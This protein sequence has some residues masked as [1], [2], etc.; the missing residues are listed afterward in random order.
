MMRFRWKKLAAVGLAAVG[1]LAVFCSS[2]AAQNVNLKQ[3]LEELLPGMGAEQG[4][5]KP[6]QRWQELCNQLGAPGQE[7]RRSEVC[8]LMAAKLASPAATPRARIWLLKQ[9]ERIGRG[10]CVDAIAAL[11]A[12]KE[13]LVQSAAI[14]ALANNPAPAAGEKLRDA[15]RMTNDSRLMIELVNAL[16][17]RGD[18]ESTEILSEELA[19]SDGELAGV[20]AR[21]LAKI[22]SPGAVEALKAALLRSSGQVRLE[23]GDALARCGEKLLAEGDVA[24]ARAIARLLYKPKEPARLAGLVGLLRTSGDDAGEA[25]LDVLAHGDAACDNI[26]IGYVANVESKS[27][28]QLADGLPG[29]PPAAQAALLHALGARR[30][31]TALEAVAQAAGSSDPAVKTAA[32]EALGGIGDRSSVPVLVQAITVGGAL[33]SIAQKSLET[34]F[35]EGVDAAIVD[36]MKKTDDPKR[37]CQYIEI[38]EHRRASSAVPAL[39]EELAKGDGNIRRRAIAA[40]CLVAAAKDVP[41]MLRGYLKIRESGERDEASRAIAEVCARAA[42]QTNQAEPVLAVYRGASAADQIALLA[43]LGRIGGPKA[44]DLVRQAAA[45]SDATRRDA[46]RQ[47]LFNWP[48]PTAAEELAKLAANVS[49]G[50]LKSRA[51]RALARVAVLPGGPSADAQLALLKRGFKEAKRDEDKRLLLESAREVHS[52]AAVKFAAESLGEPKLASQTCA[53]IVDLLHHDQI[54]NSNKVE[55][56]KLLDRVIATSKDKSLVERAR[57][58]KSA[59]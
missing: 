23:I 18:A 58:F 56:D 11:F 43:V 9:L 48:D 20:V 44:L 34:I 21:A 31:R 36:V 54:R 8:A 38:L 53:T 29:L 39:L 2:A 6:Q 12:D 59:K 49:D 40:L 25:I 4:F 42:D 22:A 45:S 3:T 57:S 26:A 19:A 1:A 13:P 41:G 32:I 28:K 33:A 7:R 16:G 10:E 27:V 15:L 14:R 47:A 55:A 30:D 24:G 17:F 50:E 46:G 37:R 52:L 35:A 5:E 51:V